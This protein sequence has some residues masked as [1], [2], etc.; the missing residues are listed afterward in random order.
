MNLYNW[1]HLQAAGSLVSPA[2]GDGIRPW[3][4]AIIL[5]LSIIVLVTMV[6]ISRRSGSE[7]KPEDTFQDE[8]DTDFME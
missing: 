7:D 6:L 5:I 4:A 1:Y 3:L 2:T 8:D